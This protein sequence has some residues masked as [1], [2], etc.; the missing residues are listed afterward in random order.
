MV[1]GLFARPP[2]RVSLSRPLALGEAVRSRIVA[3][4]TQEDGAAM[5]SLLAATVMVA[6]LGLVYRRG[7]IKIAARDR[8]VRS[9]A[10][11]Q[12]TRLTMHRTPLGK[13]RQG[14]G[15]RGELL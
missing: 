3:G 11:L 2:L 1:C 8:E 4:M 5:A 14:D 12:G 7:R 10:E 9:H 6:S 15:Q 13:V